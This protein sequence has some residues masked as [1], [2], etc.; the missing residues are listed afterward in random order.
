MM[1]HD[2]VADKINMLEEGKGGPSRAMLNSIL[3]SVLNV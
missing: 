2:A 1:M 3:L